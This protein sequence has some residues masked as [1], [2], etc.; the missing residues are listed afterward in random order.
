MFRLLGHM[1]TAP[2][3][4]VWLINRESHLAETN[5]NYLL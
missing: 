5:K 2:T 3:I 1:D 4:A